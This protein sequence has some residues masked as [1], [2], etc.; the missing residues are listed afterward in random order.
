MEWKL[1]RHGL[2]FNN[3]KLAEESVDEF[4]LIA[5]GGRVLLPSGWEQ[6]LTHYTAH[7]FLLIVTDSLDC[8]TAV[9]A[10]SGYPPFLTANWTVHCHRDGYP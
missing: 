7:T 4:C 3:P 2:A 9:L 1:L 6:F 8:E 5:I 10:L